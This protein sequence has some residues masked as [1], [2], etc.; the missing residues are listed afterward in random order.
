MTLLE[1]KIF[2]SSFEILNSLIQ[3]A[4]HCSKQDSLL[5]SIVFNFLQ[6]IEQA[7]SPP[8]DL[9]VAQ[10]SST[11]MATVSVSQSLA[12]TSDDEISQVDNSIIKY[13]EEKTED[14][15]PPEGT[16][17]KGR[18]TAIAVFL[19]LSNSLLVRKSFKS[20]LYPLTGSIVYVLWIMHGWRS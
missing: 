16:L 8:T 3:E 18:K 17:T 2:T 13:S 14:A 19:I 12:P 20:D 1:N 5:S 11:T 10:M 6:Y 4:V 15:L 9:S 7:F